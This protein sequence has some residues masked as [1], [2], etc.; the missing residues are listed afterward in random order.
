MPDSSPALEICVTWQ[1]DLRIDLNHGSRRTVVKPDLPGGV[2]TCDNTDT[3]EWATECVSS[4]SKL[5]WVW[6]APLLWWCDRWG[7]G[8]SSPPAPPMQLGL[9]GYDVIQTSVAEFACLLKAF[10]ITERGMR[11]RGGEKVSCNF[12]FFWKRRK[13]RKKK[14]SRRE[15]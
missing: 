7:R 14:K 12:N 13:K 3:P 2:F 6:S 11:G 5:I 15:L 10:I 1:Q 9:C 8:T 4:S